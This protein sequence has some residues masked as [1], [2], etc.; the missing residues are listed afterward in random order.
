MELAKTNSDLT[1][2]KKSGKSLVRDAF[3]KPKIY[4]LTDLE[5]LQ[6][7]L[8]YIFVM[9]G[10]RNIPSKEERA[11]LID[12]IKENYSIYSVEEI[13]VAFQLALKREFECETNHYE[14][15][16]CNYFGQVFDAYLKFRERIAKEY[17][18]DNQ[19]LEEPKEK[20]EKEIFEIKNNFL[21]TVLN[22]IFEKYKKTKK[23]DFGITPINIIY[24]SLKNDYDI[25]QLTEIEKEKIKK[26]SQ[27]NLYNVSSDFDKYMGI[28]KSKKE[29]YF[30]Y[31]RKKAIEISFDKLIIQDKEI[32]QK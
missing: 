10:L 20:T 26:E 17:L 11:V 29:K 16:S 2:L 23:L 18:A 24:N 8:K 25:I 31:C 27:M 32:C 1:H 12:Y 15:F 13:K 19:R 30:D 5:P 22:P 3:E 6:L 9:V 4:T 14:I 7:T 21:T 28:K